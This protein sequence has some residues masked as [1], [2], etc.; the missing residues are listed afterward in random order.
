MRALFVDGA[1]HV[2][3]PSGRFVARGEA[4]ESIEW[5]TE[6]APLVHHAGLLDAEVFAPGRSVPEGATDALPLEGGYLAVVRADRDALR[7][8]VLDAS[9]AVT[10]SVPLEGDGER[11]RAFRSG[12]EWQ[13][14]PRFSGFKRGVRLF[15]APG[16]FL[17]TA[18][19]SGH[20]A[21]FSLEE[22]RFVQ[23]LRVPG[24][25]ENTVY[26]A[27]VGDELLVG[28][29]WNGRHSEIYRASSDGEVVARWPDEGE[30]RWGMPGFA[31]VR[32]ALEPYVVT[33]SDEGTRGLV[34]LS[35]PLL[36]EI[37]VA[38][39]SAWP[40][41][42][43]TDGARFAALSSDRLALGRVRNARLV[44]DAAWTKRDLLKKAGVSIPALPQA[45]TADGRGTRVW[46][47]GG[48]TT[49]VVDGERALV[50][51]EGGVLEV[52]GS[53]ERKTLLPPMKRELLDA[54]GDRLIVLEGRRLRLLE[55]ANLVER[56]RVEPKER[57]TPRAWLLEEGF[58]HVGEEEVARFRSEFVLTWCAAPG[59]MKELARS[60]VDFEPFVLARGGDEVAWYELQREDGE[61][62]RWIVRW[63]PK[64][65]GASILVEHPIGALAFDGATLYATS[66]GSPAHLHRVDA[67]GSLVPITKE[68][69]PFAARG[70]AV[71]GGRAFFT[72]KT[73]MGSE[74]PLPSQ[75]FEVDLAT[76]EQRPIATAIVG[77]LHS[78]TVSGG[79][80]WWIETSTPGVVLPDG[81]GK[82]ASAICSLE[83]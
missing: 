58:L 37:D 44:L 24:A 55:G 52:D 68:P 38:E 70:L 3:M 6:Y 76:G 49:L 40:S 75:L 80:V 46:L 69:L 7:V 50:G 83:L 25:P 17:V 28:M 59:A 79:R 16:G 81:Q 10:L 21:R 20:V 54:R 22:R 32:D 19:A 45:A 14:G 61:E 72:V 13:R 31:T 8:D 1:L 15:P 5:L 27:C 39:L 18:N 63:R 11:L 34:L 23:L 47:E 56:M 74:G 51:S 43:A 62:E 36:E 67:D 64:G 2:A 29:K 53:G 71:G 65:Q 60:V 41:D 66:S 9:G 57:G 78:V 12:Q 82:R 33:Y 35:L 26:A 73:A 48:I 4:L 42:L 30:V 77:E